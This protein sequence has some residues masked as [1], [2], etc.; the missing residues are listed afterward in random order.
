MALPVNGSTHLI[1]AY[2]SF[3]RHR[4]DERLSWPSWLTCSGW[5]THISGHPSAAGRAQDRE[6]S[7]TRDRRSATVPRDVYLDIYL[8]CVC[9]Y[10][11]LGTAELRSSG[12]ASPVHSSVSRKSNSSGGGGG[13]GMIPRTSSMHDLLEH[14]VAVRMQSMPASHAAASTGKIYRSG[15]C[16]RL[17]VCRSELRRPRVRRRCKKTFFDVFFILVTFYVFFNVFFIFQTFFLFLK[18]RW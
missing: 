16:A 9:V 11:G 2:Y 13:P 17:S 14:G 4:K 18:K 3:Y 8:F 6:S 7:P 10:D 12:L 1:P 15:Q 5:L